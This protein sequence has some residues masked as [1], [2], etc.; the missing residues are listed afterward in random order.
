MVGRVG[1]LVRD[2]AIH[3]RAE[4]DRYHRSLDWREPTFD[5]AEVADRL[6]RQ[7]VRFSSLPGRLMRW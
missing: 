2:G 5:P 7:L 3:G 6:D 4:H 1:R